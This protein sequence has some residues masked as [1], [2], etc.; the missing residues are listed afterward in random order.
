[1]KSYSV[2]PF[3]GRK[4]LQWSRSL[5]GAEWYWKES[6]AIARK[7]SASMEPLPFRSGMDFN[8]PVS[9]SGVDASMEPLPFRSGMCHC[10]RRRNGRCT[11]ASMEPL[12][13]RSGMHLASPRSLPSTC[14]F[15]GAAPFQERNAANW[16][17]SSLHRRAASMEPL[18]FRSGMME[19]RFF[20]ELDT[21]SRLQWS[22]SL[23]GA[24]WRAVR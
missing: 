9:T 18:P 10:R 6:E 2:G 3:Q 13:F 24:E 7:I 20:R 5:S 23:S 12:P 4:T 19:T 14:C 15:N 11:T 16:R 21:I 1:M 8:W 22:R 17:V